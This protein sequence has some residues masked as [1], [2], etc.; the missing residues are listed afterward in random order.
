MRPSATNGWFSRKKKFLLP[1]KSAAHWQI[2][3][4]E[5]IPEIFYPFK[6]FRILNFAMTKWFCPVTGFVKVSLLLFF[7]SNSFSSHIKWSVI[8]SS[9]LRSLLN[10]WIWYKCQNRTENNY[11]HDE[12]Q[13]SFHKYI[14]NHTEAEQKEGS[15]CKKPSILICL[16]KAMLKKYQMS[17][18]AWRKF[19]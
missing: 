10:V 4:R 2:Y 15:S 6:L 3:W 14:S 18:L 16:T 11:H 1:W 17:D 9:S 19:S 13:L 8:T 12:E 7:L 5:V